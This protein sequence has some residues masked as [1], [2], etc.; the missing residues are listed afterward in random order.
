LYYLRTKA[1]SHEI[2]KQEL[3]WVIL[4]FNQKRGY[5]QLRGEE[6]VNKKDEKVEYK[7]LKVKDVIPTG[8]EIKGNPSYTVTFENGWEYN[9]K[10]TKPQ[11]WENQEREFIVTSKTLK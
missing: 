3:A 1:L 8:D 6:G 4:S 9:G 10:I 2:S 11:D 7:V 5:Y